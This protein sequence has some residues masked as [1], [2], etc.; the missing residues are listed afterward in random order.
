M[1]RIDFANLNYHRELIKQTLPDLVEGV[2]TL[3]CK[4][5][6]LVVGDGCA[7]EGGNFPFPRSAILEKVLGFMTPPSPE[8]ASVPARGR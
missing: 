7:R 1:P 2:S 4:R 5:P 6:G 3:L 8:T